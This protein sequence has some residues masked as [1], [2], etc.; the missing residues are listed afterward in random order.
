MPFTKSQL[1]EV[2]LYFVDAA[3]LVFIPR[4]GLLGLSVQ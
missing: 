2:A 1:M 3:K 4:N